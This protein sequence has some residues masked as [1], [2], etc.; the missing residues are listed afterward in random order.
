MAK[1]HRLSLINSHLLSQFPALPYDNSLQTFRQRGSPLNASAILESYFRDM[2]PGVI[3]IR[4]LINSSKLFDHQAEVGMPTDQLRE[5]V[6]RQIQEIYLAQNITP[7]LDEADPWRSTQVFYVLGEFDASVAT[8]LTVSV[9]LYGDTLKSLGTQKHKNLIDRVYAVHDYGSL[10]VTEMGHGS[11]VSML[12]TTATFDHTTR[13]FI[14]NSPTATSAKWWVGGVAKSSNMTA[15][16]ARLIVEGIDRGI[17]VFAIPIRDYNTHEPLPGVVIG[18]CGKKNSLNGIDN[19]FLIFKNY[20]V[21]YDCLL[22]KHSSISL[23]NKFKSHIKNNDKRLAMMLGGILRGRIGTISLAEYTMKNGLTIALRYGAVRK[24]FGSKTQES[25]ILDYQTHQYRLISNMPKLFAIRASANQMLSDFKSVRQKSRV[26]PECEEVQEYHALLSTL[27]GLS[28]QFSALTL[29]ECR[30]ACGGHGYSAHSALGRLLNNQD[31][32]STW[33]GDN[34]VLAQQ[35]GK[36][37]LKQ[38]QRMYKGQKVTSPTLQYLNPDFDHIKNY[39]A[40]F[41]NKEELLNEK[42]LFEILEYRVN[43]LIHKCINK[44]QTNAAKYAEVIDAWNNTQVFYVQELS[45]AYGERV[46]ANNLRFMADDVLAKCENTGKAFRKLL[47]LFIVERIEKSLATYLEFAITPNQADIVRETELELCKELSDHCINIIEAV[48]PP[49][50]MI[51]SIIGTSDG[52]V[53]QNIINTVESYPDV[54]KQASWAHL[55]KDIRKLT[56]LNSS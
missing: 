24:Q 41:S 23:D 12:E 27:K 8:R 6:V 54:Y 36:Y 2:T 48:A 18:D 34:T 28:T 43:Y 53:Y 16:F 55:F 20:R 15:L 40:N 3:R 9:G 42:L 51:G 30:E 39:K 13:E 25:A 31:I 7:E 11:N 33:E 38:I 32:N 56:K 52:Q 17:H 5:L 10:S 50:K 47:H 22:D 14:I 49:D 45:K 21:P 19:G 1:S 4:Q 29:K 35:T 46:M 44:L 26:D 37:L